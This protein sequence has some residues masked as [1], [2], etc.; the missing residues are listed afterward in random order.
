MDQEL[1][2]KASIKELFLNLGAVVALYTVVISLINLLFSVINTAYPKIS[3]IG[4]YAT[5]SISWP[6]A[7]LII[8]FPIM[9]LLMW[10]LEKDYAIA[11]EKRSLGIRKWLSYITLFLAGIATA[12]DLVTVLYYFIDGQEMTTGFL[13]KVLAVLV[14]ALSVFIYFISDIRGRLTS[15]HRKFW[16]GFASV[17]VVGSIIWG[18]AVIGSPRTQRLYK[19]DDAKV[20]DL[21]NISSAVESYYGLQNVLPK[22]LGDLSSIN[23]YIVQSD[24]QTGQSYEYIATGKTTYQLCAVFNKNSKDQANRTTVPYGGSSWSHPA[25]R[26]CFNMSVTPRGNTKPAFPAL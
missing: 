14:V 8:F 12:I 24:S 25:G 1:K 9:I 6:V 15:N 3:E 7:I 11:P 26:H 2:P 17:L 18:F 13:L 20:G 21:I 5:E 4:Y 10:F 22:S 23:Y 19:Y 16:T